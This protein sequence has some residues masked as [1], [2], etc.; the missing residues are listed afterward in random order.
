MSE[1]DASQI[2]LTTGLCLWKNAF[3]E[4]QTDKIWKFFRVSSAET[5]FF[6]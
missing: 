3:R 4:M 5:H 1:D 2:H 6:Q